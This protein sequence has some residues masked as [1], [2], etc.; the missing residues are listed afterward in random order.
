MTLTKSLLLGSAAG[1]V[2]V[3]SAQAADLPTRKGPVA[4]EYVRVCSITVAGAPVVGFRAENVGRDLSKLTDT[5][6]T[7]AL[8]ML[9]FSWAVDKGV[10]DIWRKGGAQALI[11]RQ[12]L[13][14]VQQ[15]LVAFE[16]QLIYGTTAPGS[17]AGFVGMV[18]AAPV[19]ALAR[20]ASKSARSPVA[21]V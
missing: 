12:G 1:L 11:A 7:V 19:A 18:A 15:A 2:A 13:A 17:A 10:A 16:K 6:V 20:A 5:V 4:V 9:D 3:A 8:K 14:H 21:V